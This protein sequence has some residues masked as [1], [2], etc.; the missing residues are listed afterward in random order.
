MTNIKTAMIDPVEEANA[1]FN[2]FDAKYPE[3]PENPYLNSKPDDS[4]DDIYT[5]IQ[6]TYD[7]GHQYIAELIGVRKTTWGIKRIYDLRQQHIL[8]GCQKIQFS[9]ALDGSDKVD[10]YVQGTTWLDI[11]KAADRAVCVSDENRQVAIEG[12]R[13]Q[14]GESIAVVKGRT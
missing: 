2:M 4:I 7:E 11:W 13:H 9:S 3:E 12:F 10:V 1:I 14:L 5:T 6:L 8:E